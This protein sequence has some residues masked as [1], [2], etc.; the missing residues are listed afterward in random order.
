MAT[1]FLVLLLADDL[2]RRAA[3]VKPGIAKTID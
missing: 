3:A 2:V 1:S